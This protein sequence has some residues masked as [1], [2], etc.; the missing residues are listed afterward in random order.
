M[1]YEI[2]VWKRCARTRSESDLIWGRRD[3]RT[4]GARCSY[5]SPQRWQRQVPGPS[6]VRL[7]AQPRASAISRRQG[8]GWLFPSSCLLPLASCLPFPSPNLWP[9]SL[10]VEQPL[11][12][13]RA[14]LQLTAPRQGKRAPPARLL[15]LPSSQGSKLDLAWHFGSLPLAIV[16]PVDLEQAPLGPQFSRTL[17]STTPHSP[18]FIK[19]PSRPCF[20]PLVAACTRK[21]QHSSRFL[22]TTTSHIAPGLERSRRPSSSKRSSSDGPGLEETRNHH[23]DRQGFE[24]HAVPL[25]HATAF[26]IFRRR[27]ATRLAFALRLL[28]LARRFTPTSLASAAPPV[29]PRDARQQQT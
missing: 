20:T 14:W 9:Q 4:V 24:T 19:F 8:A 22:T 29:R 10:L 3:G 11:C 2:F 21:P 18:Y 28:C 17:A 6:T 23:P 13:H 25:H 16:A 1:R 15:S 12:Q 5:Q 27:R 7:A 26:P